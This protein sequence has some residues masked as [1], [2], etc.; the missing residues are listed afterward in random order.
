[1]LIRYKNSEDN[2]L[3]GISSYKQDRNLS[4]KEGSNN[5][6]LHIKYKFALVEQRSYKRLSSKI[7]QSADIR[8]CIIAHER[9]YPLL[10]STFGSWGSKNER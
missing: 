8:L 10:K 5:E 3:S 2:C 9:G 1:M 4:R 7:N 6:W